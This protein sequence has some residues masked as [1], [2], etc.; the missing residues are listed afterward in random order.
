MSYPV[1]LNRDEA[2]EGTDPVRYRAGPP[3]G[4]GSYHPGHRRA[5]ILP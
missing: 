1:L 2:P 3:Q 4:R 5:D